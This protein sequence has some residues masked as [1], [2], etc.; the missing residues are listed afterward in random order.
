[1]PVLCVG[2][3]CGYT[4]Q[5]PLSLISGFTAIGLDIQITGTDLPLAVSKVMIANQE[6][7]VSTNDIG[8]ISC[9]LAQPMS[10][11]SWLPQ[12][13]S[14]AGLVPL[15]AALVPLD[16]PLVVD[17]VTPVDLSEN[18]GDLIT[19]V[20]SGFPS[21]ADSSDLKE[22]TFSDGTVCKIVSSTSTELVCET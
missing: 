3:Q 7:F 2:T 4:Y 20:G 17:S 5:V 8:Q 13:W 14:A 6:C 10:A 19:F 22:V 15:D 9:S 12:V 21:S 1:M 11:G 18:G 16:V